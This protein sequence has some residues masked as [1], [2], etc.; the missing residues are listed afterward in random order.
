MYFEAGK[1]WVSLKIS[2]KTLRTIHKNGLETVA[3]KAGVDLYSLRY[4]DVSPARLAWKAANADRP[5]PL[6]K[7][8]R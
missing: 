1:R 3:A 2:A 7:N 5:P 4:K 6:P 8:P